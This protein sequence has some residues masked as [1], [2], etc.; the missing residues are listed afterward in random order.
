MIDTCPKCSKLRSWKAKRDK[1]GFPIFRRV[2]K[3]GAEGF[4]A[5]SAPIVKRVSFP[6]EGLL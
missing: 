3:R 5:H 6:P 4:C 1:G 2:S